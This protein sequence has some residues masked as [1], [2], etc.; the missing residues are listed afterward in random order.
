MKLQIMDFRKN[1]LIT[2][3]IG[4]LLGVSILLRLADLG[5][6]DFQGDEVNALCRFSDFNT[7][8][9]FLAYLLGQRKGPVQYLVTCTL[10]IFDP[11]FSSELAARFPFAVANLIAL[12]CFFILVYRLFTLQ[13]AIFSSFL[14]ATNG[15]FISFARIVQY[16]SFVI[17]GVVAGILG[18]TVALQ[19]EKWRVTG[20]YMGFLSAA[21]GLL[22]HFDAAFVLPPMAVLVVHWWRKF[23]LRPDFA[24][25]QRH[26]I[27][28]AALFTFLVLA[29][30]IEYVSRLGPFQTEYWEGRLTGESTNIFRLFQFYNPGPVLWICLGMVIIGLTQ[31]RKSIGWQV[32]LAWLLPPLIFMVV[33]FKDS[34]THA[35]TYLLPLLIAAAVGIDRSLHW[36]SRLLPGKK[37]RLAHTIV[38]ATFLIFSSL[39][40]AIFIDHD[41]EYPWYPKHLP[42]IE[43]DGGYLVGTFGFPY[44]REWPEIAGWFDRLPN[45]EVILVTNE[46]LQIARFYLPS[47]VQYRY[48]LKD[49]PGQIRTPQGLYFLFIPGPQ[50]WM[51]EL[52]GWSFDEWQ[53]RL[54]P[55]HE[56]LNEEGKIVASVYFLT[57]EQIE[58]EFP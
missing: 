1:K 17:L 29:F 56:F 33:V 24:R 6:S 12:L 7:P 2:V 23:H 54:V 50:S 46:K 4:L 15:I 58:T 3:Q 41:P 34:R 49:F 52:W 8:L 5:Y 27:A 51:N 16:Q 25:L 21:M 31:I 18:L 44:S 47:K 43:L 11:T 35:Y 40:F 22:A 30:Y 36:L 32:T 48:G 55:Q 14:F 13:I 39:S 57:I 9:Q 37:T 28:A 53:E 10:S 26:L 42:G 19:D 20:L 45:Q 38:L